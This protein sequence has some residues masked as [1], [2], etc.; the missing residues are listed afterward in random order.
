ME[1]KPTVY[2]VDSDAAVRTALAE[3][4]GSVRMPVQCY[5][6]AEDFLQAW[7]PYRSGCI[8]LDLRLPGMS[9][10]ELQAMLVRCEYC[11]PIVFL[12]GYGDVPAAVRAM[13]QGAMDFLT[14]PI[15]GE[16]LLESIRKAMALDCERRREAIRMATIQ[17]RLE[18]LTP[19]ERQVLEGVLAGRSNKQ[20][21]NGLGISHKTV[22][23]HRS[24]MMAKLHVGS[25]VQLVEMQ[26]AAP[27]GIRRETGGIV[28][29][30]HQ[31][32]T[33]RA[34]HELD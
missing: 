20:I 32:I 2:V 10:L 13:R 30:A 17:A 6:S 5:E 26:A 34:A 31:G 18:L 22:E 8:L 23:Q 15:S 25:I 14:K 3:L 28:Y 12:T 4:F 24:H 19:R 33:Q 21:G 16:S 7:R 11:P 27:N 1:S 9:G 29:Q